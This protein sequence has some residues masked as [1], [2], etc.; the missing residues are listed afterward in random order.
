MPSSHDPS[1]L[2]AIKHLELRARAVMEGLKAGLHRSPYSGF[3]V[4]FTEYRQYTPGDDLRY[5]DWKALARTDRHYIKKYEDETDLRCLIL[6]DTSRSMQFGSRGYTKLDY[7]RTLAATLA[8]FLHEQRDVVGTALFDRTVHHVVPPRWRAG[9]LQHV[10]AALDREPAAHE[11]HLT[12]A[13]EE[14]ARMCRKR[15]LIFILSDFLAPSEDWSTALGHLAAARHDVRA[16]QVIDPAERSL[17]FGKAAVW[18]DLEDGRTLYIDPAQARTGYQQRFT[19]HET[20]LRAVFA[21]YGV[22]STTIT[23]D[24]PLDQALIRFLSGETVRP[25]AAATP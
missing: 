17:E 24:E 10:L 8:C 1:A 14:V 16:L 15:T 25:P 6:L 20:A 19:A 9:H 3:S 4:E 21:T 2:L 13:L 18:E 5:L 22:A 12:Q 11:T 7:A 23:T